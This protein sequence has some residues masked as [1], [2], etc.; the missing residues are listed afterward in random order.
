LSTPKGWQ[1][2]LE[3]LQEMNKKIEK[4]AGNA[5]R[6]ESVE[7]TPKLD[8]KD[9]DPLTWMAEEIV[10][11]TAFIPSYEE[12]MLFVKGYLKLVITST[13]ASTRLLD[14]L[15]EINDDG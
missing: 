8:P 9:K 3:R 7:E 14:E 12:K 1:E 2:A 11:V 4:I 15:D 6:E 10:R 13:I 5:S